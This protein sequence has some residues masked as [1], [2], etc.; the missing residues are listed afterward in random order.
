MKI[1]RGQEDMRMVSRRS[2]TKYQPH[3]QNEDRLSYN[4]KGSAVNR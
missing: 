3:C 4:S 2:I 1:S